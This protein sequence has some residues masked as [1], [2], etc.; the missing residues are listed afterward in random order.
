M[1]SNDEFAVIVK[2]N[3][4]LTSKAGTYTITLGV[5]EVPSLTKKIQVKVTDDSTKPDATYNTTPNLLV[6]IFDK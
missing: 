5:T 2:D 6:E 1:H 4:G 3:G